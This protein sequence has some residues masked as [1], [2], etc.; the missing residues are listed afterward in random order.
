MGISIG[1]VVGVGLLVL[2]L[3]GAFIVSGE[4]SERKERTRRVQK[5]DYSETE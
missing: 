4:A 1:L 5:D 3:A 2:G